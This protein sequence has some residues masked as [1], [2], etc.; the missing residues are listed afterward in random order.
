LTG[1]SAGRPVGTNGPELLARLR[2]LGVRVW[3]E[4]GRVRVSAPKGVMT[5]ALRDELTLHRD[6]LL[7]ALSEG[8]PLEGA[9]RIERRDSSESIPLS[10]AQQRLW[11][12]HQLDPDSAAYTIGAWF[13][14]EGP[15]DVRAL[16]RAIG[17]I[18][19]RHEILRTTF[20]SVD[21]QPVQVIETSPPPA[22]TVHDLS[23]LPVAER[24]AEADR[25][26]SEE[27]RRPFDLAKGSL[28]RARL[29]RLGPTEHRLLFAVHHIVFD[30][31][32]L[33]VLGKDFGQLYAAYAQGTTPS[34]PNLPIQYGDFAVWQQR[35][36]TGSLL[37]R[38]REY[39]LGRLRGATGAL[40]L[41]TDRRRS[42]RS[43]S[44]GAGYA[45][46]LSRPLSLAVK[47]VARQKGVTPFVTLLAAFVAL[48][49]RYTG[50]D[51]VVVGSPIANRTRVE[52]EGLIGMFANT[53]VLRTDVSGDPTFA[54]LVGRVW[55]IALGAFE[56]Q[57]MPFEK[58]VEE[59]QPERALG[60][61]PLFQ[62]TFVHQ[63]APPGP[64]P[65]FVTVGSPFD[66]SLFTTEDP[67]GSFR[68]AIQYRTDLFL[69]AT[70]ERM[71]G[72]LQELLAGATADPG[73]RVSELPLLGES[74][75]RRMIVDWN[76]TATAYPREATID[77][78]FAAQARA[79]PD[80]VAVVCGERSLT[81]GELDRQANR[82]AHRL[83]Q[84]GTGPER[85]VAV[86]ME[87][88]LEMV[89]AV[90]AVL[91][92][93]GAYAALD[94]AAPGDR[95]AFMLSDAEVDVVL[96][97]SAVADRLPPT[98]GQVL[99]LDGLLSG[100]GEAAPPPADT[101]AESLAYVIYTSGSTGQPKAVCATHR[102]VV[103]LVKSTDYAHFG[104]DEVVLQ[105]APLSFDA[106]TFEL[107]G[108]LLNGGRL[109][110]APPGV[111][112]VDE[113]ASQ[114]ARHGV[115]T[116]WLTAGL[117]QQVVDERIEALSGLRQLLAGGDV[118]S[119]PHVRRVLTGLPGCRLIN[120]Y[121]PTENTTFTCCATLT[122]ATD[123]ERSV[124]IGRP[125]ANSRVYVLDRGRH[126]VPIGIPGELW[127]GGDGLARGYLNRAELT[128]ERFVTVDLGAGVHERLYRSGDLVRYLADGSL[129][130][131][132][133][134]DDQ[135]KLRGFRVEPG[136]IETV[137][138]RHPDVREAA[139]VVRDGRRGDKELVAYVVAERPVAAPE[140]RDFLRRTLPDY[141]V[142]AAFVFLD[143]LPLTANGKVDRRALP[144][145][146]RTS[147]AT[148]QRVEPTDEL[149]RLLVGIWEETLQVSPIG[150]R[151]DFFDLGGHSLLAVRVFARLQR[152]LGHSLPLATLFQ[153]P[154]IEAL[155]ALIRS[156][157]WTSPWKSLVPIQPHGSRV[158]IFAVPGVGG[159]VLGFNDLARLLGLDQPFYGLQSVG[160]SGETEPLTRIEDIAAQFLG[161][162]RA[163]QPQGPYC[164]LGACM[165]GV[166]A[167]EMAQQLA[168]AGQRV[169]LLALLE[170]WRPV[171][172]RG[173]PRLGS[174]RAAVLRFAA[175]RML[176]YTRTLW[177]LEP[178]ERREYIK[179]RL[180]T[181]R[182]AIAT[183]D[184][185]RGDRSELYRSRVTQA[186]LQAF[187]QYVAR[188]YPGSLVVFTAEDRRSLTTEDGRLTWRELA[189]GGMDT[190]AV[191]GHDSGSIMF[192]PH[193]RVLVEHLQRYL[194]GSR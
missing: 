88:S 136:E 37:A 151:D 165:G 180:M 156:G 47:T 143:R 169:S 21:G 2:G 81:Y 160:L 32:S 116:L 82:L 39:W 109:V 152:R 111:P 118:L 29:L 57:D 89:V 177:Q 45:F 86:W 99:Q 182:E 145:P 20:A 5:D 46:D 7:A 55:D 98:A 117:F 104:P 128:A 48:L 97:A 170:T 12:L 56:H 190:H 62:V 112:S 153:A 87:R 91:K 60:Q 4:G 72:H 70:I 8:A 23:D 127:I 178:A 59:L 83:R 74:E 106:S 71:A 147:G 3:L 36:L 53:L 94:L 115:T 184:V 159:H 189:T 139:V 92:A 77:G 10:F 141:M 132:G 149:E 103:R 181:L 175:A 44:P 187:R 192:E 84:L 140:L 126:P 76:A 18:V 185:F 191:P 113:L 167:Y 144:E 68:G 11:F 134:L 96:T 102:G 14:L 63:Q 142:P 67:D 64:R 65:T 173:A 172:A 93:G 188:P 158:P 119:V 161:E 164:L 22:L 51:D 174:P 100:A 90:L 131:L 49:H 24:G 58:L 124:P 114:L 186:N 85:V 130:F 19:L 171:A 95:L 17:D 50:D 61:N 1:P 121:G 129:E 101:T 138:L 33:G 133:R 16:E 41:A 146:D 69:P 163:I 154:T 27:V 9:H 30:G 78:L 135:V 168:A 120:G 166:V 162:V 125:I 79:T 110:V 108:A 66:L 150:I 183:R 54:E 6:E 137:L 155:A 25:L 179:A 43:E 42:G 38:H 176:L 13:G 80:A 75:R 28:F 15:L 193:V 123:L 148:T 73:R 107:W 26:A 31:W 194:S 52:V 40:T 34:L 122:P 157:G 105:L 35:S